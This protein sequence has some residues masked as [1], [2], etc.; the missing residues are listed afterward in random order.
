MKTKIAAFFDRLREVISEFESQRDSAPKPRVARNELPWVKRSRGI[1]PEGVASENHERG[2]RNHVVVDKFFSRSSQG[3]LCQPWALG[4]NPFGILKAKALLRK[5]QPEA[6]KARASGRALLLIRK[7]IFPIGL[8][9][10]VLGTSLITGCN[11]SDG[12]GAAPKAVAKYFCPMHPTYTSDR[13]G[14]CPICGMKLVLIKPASTSS[15]AAAPMTNVPGRITIHIDAEKQQLIGVSTSPVERRDLVR[16]VRTT[17]IAQHDET[18]LFKITPRFGG[19]VRKLFVNYTGQ[20]VSKGDPLFTVYSPELFATEREYL[21]AYQ[22]LQK[23]TTASP[24]LQKTSGRLL[25]SAKK[26]LSL[27]QISDEEIQQLEKRGEAN[28]ELIFRS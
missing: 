25:E 6:Q 4:R 27:W 3:R 1:N 28:D 9:A 10:L 20:A 17:G 13:P 5:D 19:F 8:I 22:Q 24:E 7:M 15:D 18:R 14:D 16:T 26:R 12:P 23:A 21:L 2:G 11:K